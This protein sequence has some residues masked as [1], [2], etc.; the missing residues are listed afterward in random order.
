MSDFAARFTP[1]HALAGSSPAPGGFSRDARFA[2]YAAF[3][4]PATARPEAP[5]H[6]DEAPDPVTLA[7][8]RGYDA[9]RAEAMA[10]AENSAVMADAARDRFALSFARMDDELA[11]AL[12]QRLHETVVA[13]CEETLHPLALDAEALAARVERAVAMFARAD[14]ERTIR[15]NP[16]DLAVVARL[17]PTEWTFTPD[18][19]L[20]RGALRV[21]TQTGGVEDGP[22]QWR[23]A[24][25]EALRL[26]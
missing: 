19:A 17:L 12:R 9:G 20:P 16:D 8:A 22:E 26:C 21:E 3:A 1:G 5:A 13:L 25:I 2:G 23:A 15:L 24:V 6:A 14:D 10:E 11:E 4:A 18:P 7:Y